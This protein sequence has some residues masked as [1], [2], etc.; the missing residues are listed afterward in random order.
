M[1]RKRIVGFPAPACRG[2]AQAGC[3]RCKRNHP[4]REIENHRGGLCSR[5]RLAGAPGAHAIWLPSSSLLSQLQTTPYVALCGCTVTIVSEDSPYCGQSGRVRRV[6]WR[7]RTAWVLVRLGLGGLTAL[8][9]ACTDLPVPQL[10]DDGPDGPP[11]SLL[12][13]TALQALARFLQYRR[14]PPRQ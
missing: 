4:A 5:C 6:F 12:S 1:S 11:P 7:M 2:R 14:P 3:W 8:P 9:W 13:P 10:E